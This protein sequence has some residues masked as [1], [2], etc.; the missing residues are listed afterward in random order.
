MLLKLEYNA[1]KMQKNAAK[2]QSCEQRSTR[3]PPLK[4]LGWDSSNAPLKRRG[5][6]VGLTIHV[7]A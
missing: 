6:A 3:A 2:K 4:T 7:A 1:R 5:F